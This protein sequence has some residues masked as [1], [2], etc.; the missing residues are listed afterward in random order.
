MARFLAL[1]AA[2]TLREILPGLLRGV[3]VV[4]AA[5][6]TSGLALPG[7]PQEQIPGS[8][9]SIRVL[10]SRLTPL[11]VFWSAIWITV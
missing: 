8:H 1:I 5:E 10:R 11:G 9:D 7:C 3:W 6:A 4:P 2:R